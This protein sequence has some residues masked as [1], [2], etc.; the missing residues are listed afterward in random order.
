LEKM[1]RPDDPM[2]FTPLEDRLVKY[3]SR[4]EDD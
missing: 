1:R 4:V 3:L 2:V